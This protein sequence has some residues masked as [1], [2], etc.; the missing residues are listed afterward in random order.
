VKDRTFKIVFAVLLVIFICVTVVVVRQAWIFKTHRDYF[1]Q[2][3]ENQ[4]IQDWM[5][6]RVI[7]KYYHINLQEVLH[8]TVPFSEL[9]IPIAGY[10][11]KEK[12]DCSKIVSDLENY[13]ELHPI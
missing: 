9:R 3:L 12:V 7:E 6:F 1:K 13:K 4:K 10:C 11:A 5:T 8:K 2:P